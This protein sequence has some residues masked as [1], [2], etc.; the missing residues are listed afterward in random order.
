[1]NNYK[2]LKPNLLDPIIKKK[3]IKTLKLPVN[4]Y[5][6]PVKSGLKS[7]IENYIKPNIGLVVFII[8]IIIFLIYRYR[9]I[10]EEKK[11]TYGTNAPPENKKQL[12]S[13]TN[14][15]ETNEYTDLLLQLYNSQKENL[16]EP[17]IKQNRHIAT[18]K[19]AYPMYPYAQ[20]GTLAPS[21]G[22]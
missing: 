2:H 21:N 18:T 10:K 16:R 4:D 15:H 19:F 20:G 1:M 5:W 11:N 3:I 14:G 9:T 13:D 7:F 6:A 22:R 12:H 17:P 8:L